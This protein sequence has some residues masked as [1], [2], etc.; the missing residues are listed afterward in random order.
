MSNSDALIRIKNIVGD[1]KNGISPLVAV[2]K[3]TLW[4]WVK[5]ERF[6]QPAIRIGAA[7]LWRMSDIQ[8]WI[9]DKAGRATK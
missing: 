2:S 5:E 7:T 8:N 6:P 1:P 9:A 3:A 4:T